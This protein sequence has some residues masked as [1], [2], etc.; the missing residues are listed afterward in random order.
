LNASF[1]RVIQPFSG[2]IRTSDQLFDVARGALGEVMQAGAGRRN[3]SQS[4]FI[5]LLA[6]PAQTNPEGQRMRQELAGRMRTVM[7]AQRLTSF[8]T[9]FGLA[10]GLAGMSKGQAASDG[11]M[12][13]A[14]ELREFELPQPIFTDRE[15]SEWAS[16]LRKNPHANLQVKVDLGQVMRRSAD[17]PK[18]LTEARGLL[19]PF[20][21]D[22]LV[23]LNYAYYEPP[24]GPMTSPDR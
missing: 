1:Q 20:F 5:T 4:E 24:G 22:V 15:R 19:T 11:L 21:R 2:T 23:G 16:G 9:L 8:D 12:R 10:D 14:G 17:D 6:G 7:D 18:E 13:L 3:L